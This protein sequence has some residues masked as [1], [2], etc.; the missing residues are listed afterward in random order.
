MELALSSAHGWVLLVL[1]AAILEI[2]R[3][4]AP[5]PC[6]GLAVTR[7]QLLHRASQLPA[8]WRRRRRLAITTVQN[9][10]PSASLHIF[11]AAPCCILLHCSTLGWV[12]SST[13]PASA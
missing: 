11:V 7:H 5:W 13:A 3:P 12:V 10:A 6:L 4:A 1:A 9:A 8:Q 2:V